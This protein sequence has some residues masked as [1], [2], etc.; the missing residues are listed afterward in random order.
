MTRR[1]H[2]D[3]PD[4]SSRSGA[5]PAPETVTQGSG[6]ALS[7][8]KVD[9]QPPEEI[10]GDGSGD[11]LPPIDADEPP[12]ETSESDPE[13]PAE[14]PS[15]QACGGVVRETFLTSRVSER[16]GPR[17]A[18]VTPTEAELAEAPEGLLVRPTPEQLAA[19]P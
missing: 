10:T 4:R 18:F 6:E 9:A 1:S 8:I 13:R 7:P 17:G 11:A 14:Q 19:R 15:A 12:A 2:R 3:Q 16:F 5:N